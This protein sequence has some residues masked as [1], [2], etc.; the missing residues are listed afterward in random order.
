M[1]NFIAFKTILR[2]EISRFM[3]IWGQTLVP[4][5]ITIALYFMIFG[6]LMGSRIG[7]MDGISYMK[8]IT[9][10]LIMMA[11]IS[12]SYA[13]VVSSFFGAKYGK[14]IEELVVASVSETTILFGYVIGGLSRGIVVALIVTVVALSFSSI[15]IHSLFITIIFAFLT[16]ALFALLGLINAIFANKF[17]DINIVP[18]FVLTPMT[19]LGGIFYS[20]DLLP[21]FWQSLTHFNPIFYMINGFRY[22]MLGVSDIT[23]MHSISILCVFIVLAYATALTLLKKGVGIRS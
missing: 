8:F 3:R 13:N 16:A 7:S 21:E 11:I 20:V 10:G 19:Y 18:T 15:Q 5:A 17:D 6:T 22:G 4:P 2:R 14:H 9:P 1:N 12:N 23:V